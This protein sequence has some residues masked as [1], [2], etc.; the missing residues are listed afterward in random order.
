MN[1]TI[2]AIAFVVLACGVSFA[3][4]NA[5]ITPGTQSEYEQAVSAGNIT[6]E[7]GNVTAVNIDA[8]TSTEKWAG[9]FGN[10][11]GT[12]VLAQSG[13]TSFLYNWTANGTTGEVC[14]S[15]TPNWGTLHELT[16]AVGGLIDTAWGFNATEADSGTNT[17]NGSTNVYNIEAKDYTTDA[18]TTG[19]GF[20]TGIF[21][22]NTATPT[23]PTDFAFCVN[24]TASG[25]YYKGTDANYE[26]MAPT[27]D[28]EDGSQTQTYYFF[29]ELV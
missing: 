13:D 25:K 5:S 23:V 12:I 10:V 17:V 11:T 26:L 14:V 16:T 8:N 28:S 2:W 4:D 9:F 7:G 6:T 24:T 22:F 20:M 27:P 15:A 29:V 19:G 18:I 3:M 21:G 1:K